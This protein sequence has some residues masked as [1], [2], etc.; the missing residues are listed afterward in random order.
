MAAP[1]LVSEETSLNEKEPLGEEILMAS[2][3][4]CIRHAGP[5]PASRTLSTYWMPT[6]AGMTIELITDSLLKYHK[7]I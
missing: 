5:D 6:F 7:R 1:P 4:V 3:K 2:E